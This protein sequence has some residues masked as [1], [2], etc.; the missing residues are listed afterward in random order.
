MFLHCCAAILVYC[1]TVHYLC[2]DI[3]VFDSRTKS[4]L[5]KHLIETHS[6]DSLILGKEQHLQCLHKYKSISCI[7]CAFFLKLD[8]HS[9]D[10]DRYCI[11]GAD[12][13]D[14]SNLDEQLK[15]F[16]LNPE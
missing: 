9:L 16:Q 10:S 5:S 6:T 4:P 11:I 1:F 7:T 3:F 8:T 12:L 14:I 2:D 15:K 13:R